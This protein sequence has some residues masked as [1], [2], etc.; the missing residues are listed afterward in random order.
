M[1]WPAEQS[2]AG[3]FKSMHPFDLKYSK[4]LEESTATYAIGAIGTYVCDPCCVDCPDL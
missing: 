2:M 4:L 1:T 3:H